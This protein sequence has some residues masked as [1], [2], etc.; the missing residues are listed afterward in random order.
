MTNLQRETERSRLTL[1]Q[2]LALQP[3]LFRAGTATITDMETLRAYV[4]YENA[5]RNRL[6]VL[7]RLHRRADELREDEK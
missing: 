1:K 2:R 5:H 3:R 6:V 4:A 7:R